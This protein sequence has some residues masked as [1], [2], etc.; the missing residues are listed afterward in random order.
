MHKKWIKPKNSLAIEIQNLSKTYN[1]SKKKTNALL[2]INLNIKC[3]CFY[4]LLGPNGAGKSTIIN[5]LG[6]TTTKDKGRIKIWGLNIDTQRKQSKLAIGIVPQE[7]YIDAFFTPRDQLELQ[8]GLF[9]VP[10]KQRV[11]DYILELM[12]LTDKA[13]EYSRNLSGGMRRRLLVAKAMVHN[14]PIIILDEPTAG[15]D[16]E[17][18]KKLWDNFKKLN[19]E[20]VTIILTTHYLEE[21]ETL[22]DEIAIIHRGKIVANDNKKNLL[23]LIDKKIL[24]MRFEESPNKILINALS[25]FGKTKFLKKA[26]EITF[27]PT[28]VSIDKILKVTKNHG[29]TILDLQTKDANLEDVFISLTQN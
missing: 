25:K 23:K 6:G 21:A 18:R 3:G 26:C 29:F 11:T 4:G 28:N 13:N 14:P 22:C 9:N 27:K 2:G 10:K 1:N 8:A 20:G 12:E 7:L 17:L 15:V 24:I 16:I 19:E 5:I